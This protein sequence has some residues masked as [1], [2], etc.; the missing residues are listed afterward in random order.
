[1]PEF[2]FETYRENLKQAQ[3]LYD[4]ACRTGNKVLQNVW[5]GERNRILAGIAV[6]PDNP[7]NKKDNA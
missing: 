6:H 4:E 7:R 3:R 1:M 5:Y 2:T